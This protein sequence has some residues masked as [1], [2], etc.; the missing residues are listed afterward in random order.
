MNN[1]SNYFND[2]REIVCLFTRPQRT[3]DDPKAMPTRNQLGLAMSG[4]ELVNTNLDPTEKYR[5]TNK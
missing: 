2:L 1:F 5:Q 3:A 4:L